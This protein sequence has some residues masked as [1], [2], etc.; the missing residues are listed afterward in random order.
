[1]S[2]IN[3]LIVGSS[4]VAAV[5][6]GWKHLS[7]DYP[8]AKVDFLAAP[9][10]I[11]K[12]FETDADGRYGLHKT[13]GLHPS[14]LEV[15]KAVNGELTRKLADYSHVAVIG[16]GVGNNSILELM[17][18]CGVDQLRSP[19]GPAAPLISEAAFRAVCR[20][21]TVPRVSESLVTTFR[22]CKVLVVPVPVRSER[23]L[24]RTESSSELAG[25]L[26]AHPE[27]VR[28]LY[29]VFCDVVTGCFAEKG[30]DFWPQPADTLSEFGFSAQAY[31]EG[32]LR[33]DADKTNEE[34]SHLNEKYGRVC[35]AGILRWAGLAA[36]PRADA[37]AG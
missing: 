26:A 24:G 11:F 12:T 17:S 18:E 13:K 29:R 9:A 23:V 21:I 2:D 1:M 3:I 32:S 33:L 7:G 36:Q 37:A 15:V 28:E 31:T 8:D 25:A 22:G 34:F 14:K 5:A 19:P 16:H 10:P 4:H 35:M 30:L 20:D 27:G 6:A